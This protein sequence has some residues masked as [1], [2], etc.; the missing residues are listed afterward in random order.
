MHVVDDVKDIEDTNSTQEVQCNNV[1]NTQAQA[2]NSNKKGAGKV[3]T[4]VVT[5]LTFS[6]TS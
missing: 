4:T 2:N 5:N 1:S 3:V 6:T